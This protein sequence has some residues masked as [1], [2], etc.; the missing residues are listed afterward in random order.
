MSENKN[1]CFFFSSFRN[2]Y[3]L[4]CSFW[5]MQR[6]TPDS[7]ILRL[8]ITMKLVVVDY[9]WNEVIVRHE[10]YSPFIFLST[11]ARAHARWATFFNGLLF[12]SLT[13]IYSEIVWMLLKNIPMSN[14]LGWKAYIKWFPLNHIIWRKKI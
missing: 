7:I 3:N 1:F 9:M 2:N 12:V 5:R 14:S 8:F 13:W 11:F 6:Q 10:L 4:I